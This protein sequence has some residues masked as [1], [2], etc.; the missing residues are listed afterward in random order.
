[1]LL[2]HNKRAKIDTPSIDYAGIYIHI[3][4]CIRKCPY[5]DFYSITDT[6]LKNRFIKALLKEIEL[7]SNPD[8]IVDTIYFGGGTPSILN[9]EDVERII[10]AIAKSFHLIDS[11]F[12]HKGEN[13]ISKNKNENL[14][15]YQNLNIS[16]NSDINKNL[17]ITMEVNPCT[18]KD[19]Y[20]RDI[21]I[22]GINRLSIGVQSFQDDKLNFLNRVHSADK[23][24]KTII[25]AREA[26]FEDIGIDLIYGLPD[27]TENIWLNDLN[28]AYEYRPAHLS[29]YI[30][31]YEHDTPMFLA[32]EKGNIKP[33]DDETVASLFKLTSN[34]LVSKGFD[35]YEISNFAAFPKYQ[36]KH[37]KKYWEMVP[38]LGFGPSAHSY[39]CEPTLQQKRFWNVKDVNQYIS[40][41]EQSNSPIAE[42]EWL[43]REQQLIELIMVGLRTEKGI[44]IKLFEELYRA[45]TT[46]DNSVSQFK[47]IF[48]SVLDK[49]ETKSLGK[50]EQERVKLTIEG[51]LFLDTI[52]QWFVDEL[53]GYIS[54]LEIN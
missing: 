54:K 25:S 30:L 20:L 6:F 18:V 24:R 28:A 10:E 2:N 50:I 7:R 23:A 9:C 26:G 1:M 49:I 47:I 36:S 12:I 42:I 48:K 14:T 13:N 11:G 41:L 51:W 8:L 15:P 46:F 40:M 34:Y 33:L 39:C 19:G 3:P 38:Y 53:E 43:T 16:E 31:S 45:E 35:H 27:E 4:F 29:C 21:K 5:C 44:D 17:K 52:I 22:V 37:N 32:Y